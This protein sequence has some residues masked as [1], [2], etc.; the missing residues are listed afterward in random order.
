M[1]LTK[2]TIL[3]TAATFVLGVSSAKAT[4]SSVTNYSK[5]N[6][7]AT[8]ITNELTVSGS[9]YTYTTKKAKIGN[10]QLLDLFAGWDGADRT[11][12]PWKSAKLVVGWSQGWDGDVLVLDKTGTNVLFDADYNPDAYFTVDFHGAPGAYNGYYIEADPGSE[13]WTV[14]HSA[15]YTLYDNDYYLNYTDLSGPGGDTQKFKESWNAS[16]DG[17]GWSDQESATFP[18]QGDQYFLDV[19]DNTTVSGTISASGKGKG[20]NSYL[21]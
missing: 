14:Q 6:V 8:I 19:G 17:T 16:G 3:A 10:K 5:L 13:N 9:K 4:I 21:D 12:N 15:D 7:S 1:K 11:V 20:V 2:L 18:Y